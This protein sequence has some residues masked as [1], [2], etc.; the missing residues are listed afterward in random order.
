MKTDPIRDYILKSERNLGIARAVAESWPAVRSAIVA[1]FIDRL[2]ARLKRKLKDWES[3]CCDGCFFVD[4]W[5]GYYIWK[6]AW[7]NRAIGIQCGRYG[8]KMLLGVVRETNNT[9]AV[10]RHTPL[11]SA[12]QAVFPS[13][14]AQTWWEASVRL[15][16]PGADWRE[17]QVLWRMH[18]DPQFVAV[19]AEQL[20]QIAEKTTRIIDRVEK[21][22]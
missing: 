4:A 8:E 22:K 14:K 20:L 13:A 6:P 17:T 21:T 11:L 19:V 5:A 9:K 18:Q 7:K 2:D 3:G 10:P 1:G 12:V 16:W 15:K